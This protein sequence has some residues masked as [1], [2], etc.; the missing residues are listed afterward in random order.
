MAN[1]A[2][3][4]DEGVASLLAGIGVGVVLGAAVALLLAPQPGVRTRAL[5]RDSADDAL[6]RL[7]H[8]MDDLRS[9]VE[10]IAS[11]HEAPPAPGDGAAAGATDEPA[12]G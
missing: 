1:E 8:S 3:R 6:Q 7:R 9:R 11:R 12:A 5:L 2:Q 10:E 4:G